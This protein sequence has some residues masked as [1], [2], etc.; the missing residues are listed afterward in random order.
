MAFIEFYSLLGVRHFTF[1]N[2][3][4]GPNVQCVL[5]RYIKDNLISILPWYLN[6]VS[7]IEIRTEGL[8]AAFNDCMY[9]NMY[10]SRYI[11]FVDIDEFIVP[12]Q[13]YT[14]IQ[15]IKYSLC[16]F[17]SCS[18][19]YEIILILILFVVPLNFSQTIYQLLIYFLMHFFARNILMMN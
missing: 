8:F 15:L 18:N 5:D 19:E 17:L 2:G 1:Y 12:K 6:M 10:T 3:T 4:I 14:L 7:K 13:N 9:R 16:F 11:V